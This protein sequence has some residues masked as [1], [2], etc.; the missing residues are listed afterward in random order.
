MVIRK[1][2]GRPPSTAL[3]GGPLPPW[4]GG[5]RARR[6]LPRPCGRRG[7]HAKHG[8]GG[9]P[10]A[11]A[12]ETGRSPAD[13][14][15]VRIGGRRASRRRSR[16]CFPI[17]Q[18]ASPAPPRGS[19]AWPKAIRCKGGSASWRTLPQ[20]R[21]PSPRRCRLSPSQ[22]N[23]SSGRGRSAHPADRRRRLAARCDLARRPEAAS[24]IVS[25]RPLPPAAAAVIA[26]LRAAPRRGD[27]GAGGRL[28]ARAARPGRRR[29][30]LLDRRGA[31]DCFHPSR[32]RPPRGLAA[33]PRAARG[34]VPAAARRLRRGSPGL[35]PIAR[36]ALSALLAMLDRLA[37][38][39]C[40]LT[41]GPSRT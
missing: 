35:G 34:C 20:P 36:G 10:Q 28:S 39:S 15:L 26:D 30:G 19:S 29:R 3:A 33:P 16:S 27:R 23:A 37:S 4:N 13:G 6:L 5:G 1:R 24:S 7:D 14:R 17:P 40:V 31:A 22:T 38:H 2:R 41:L 18:R 21:A 25:T 9:E 8:G 12:H 32:G 11:R